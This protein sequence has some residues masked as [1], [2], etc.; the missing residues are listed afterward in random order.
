MGDDETAYSTIVR[1]TYGVLFFGCPNR[2][3]NIESLIPMCEGQPNLP[4]LCTLGQD[5]TVLR[6]LCREWPAAFPYADA[7]IIAFYETQLSP[8]ARQVR[9][10]SR[11]LWDRQG[12]K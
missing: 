1:A 11:L 4:F 5:S 9:M 6:Q 8:T 10:S 12:E 3:M 2:G 7:R